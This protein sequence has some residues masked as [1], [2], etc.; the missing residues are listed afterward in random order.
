MEQELLETLDRA[1]KLSS[2]GEEQLGLVC[3]GSHDPIPQSCSDIQAAKLAAILIRAGKIDEGWNYLQRDWTQ[4]SPIAAGLA[5]A[6]GLALGIPDW[7]EPSLRRAC[8]ASLN[9]ASHWINLGRCL[10]HMGQTAE[11]V[12]HLSK[13][14]SEAL[15][16]DQAREWR[17]SSVE[18]Q[19]AAGNAEDALKLV[20]ANGRDPE[21]A[22]IRARVLAHLGRHDQAFRE[23]TQL[24]KEQ[25]QQIDLLLATVD[26]AEALG[27]FQ[28]SSSA[29]EAAI[30]AEPKRPEFWLRLVH[31]YCGSLQNTQAERALE[32]A[33]ELLSDASVA[34]QASALAAEARVANLQSQPDKAEEL[35]K[36][37]LQLMP[38]LLIGLSGLGN[39][40]MQ[41]GRIPEAIEIFRTITSVAPLSGWTHLIQAHQNLSDPAITEA[42][43]QAAHQPSLEGPINSGLLFS[44]AA[45]HDKQGNAP[46]AFEA[47]IKANEACKPNLRYSAPE[48]RHHVD[49]ILQ[50]FSTSFFQERKGWGCSSQLPLFIVGMP[51]SGTTL[52]EQIVAS[53]PSVYGAGELGHIPGCIAQM[54]H[55]E[56]RLGSPL[57][58]PYCLNELDQASTRLYAE[59]IINELQALE[60]EEKKY[61]TDKL[62]H[63]FEN[64]GLIRLLF[65]RCKIIHVHREPRDVAVSNYLTDYAAKQGGMGF[66]YDLQWIGEQLIDEQ[67][68]SKHWDALFPSQILH[69]NYESLINNPEQEVRRILIYLELEWHESLMDFQGLDRPVKTASVWQVR[70][71]IYSSSKGRW[72]R[73]AK[74]LKPL[75]EALSQPVNT[76]PASASKPAIPA[77][78]FHAGMRCLQNG[79]AKQAH[80]HFNNLLSRY[81]N[82]AAAEHFRGVALLKLGRPQEALQAIERSVRRCPQHPAWQKNLEVARKAAHQRPI[83]R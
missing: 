57:Q 59:Q 16:A 43:E 31:S 7:A 5:G 52:T 30:K 75:E 18:A 51:R 47:A 10:V 40:Y 72:Q 12:E 25:P 49:S 33:K 4:A 13:L 79:N 42:L 45:H 44:L 2:E 14:N 66:A 35:Y 56:Q 73:Y 22:A 29:L 3:L 82:H 77:G 1:W 36:Q 32:K 70:Q 62:P 28:M 69:V 48:H 55:W 37:A 8:E 27:R 81:P 38:L 24:L 11:A 17:L 15:P 41:I 76:P 26:L 83:H 19:I 53:H 68:L 60:S 63:N 6:M 39:L 71:P 20:P 9:D 80:D 21:T 46:K 50:H 23:L 74:Y 58:Y 65:P 61:I 78:S 34:L 64:I 54:E 67:R